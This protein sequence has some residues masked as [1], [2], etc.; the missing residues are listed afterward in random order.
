M[1]GGTR[2]IKRKGKGN[3]TKKIAGAR[4]KKTRVRNFLTNMIASAQKTAQKTAERAKNE[5]VRQRTA[6][7]ITAT[8]RRLE[9]NGKPLLP[10][11]ERTKMEVIDAPLVRTHRM[12][13]RGTA[14]AKAAAAAAAAAEANYKAAAENEALQKMLAKLNII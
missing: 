12:S 10:R 4:S 5:S 6:R 3:K 13:T 14:M 2:R 7:F 11:G 9:N 1:K 8:K